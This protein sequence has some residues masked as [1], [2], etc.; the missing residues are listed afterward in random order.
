MEIDLV[1]LS[2]DLSPPRDDVMKGVASQGLAGLRVLRVAGP[3]RPEDPNRWATIARARNEAKHVGSAPFVMFLDDDVVLAPGCVPS[4]LDGLRRR[5]IFA[6]LGADYAEEMAANPFHHWDYPP[7]V[8]MGAVLFRR[9]RLAGINFRWENKR[10]ECACCC[11]DLRSAGLAVGYHPDARATH[12]RHPAAPVAAPAAVPQGRVLAAFNRAHYQKF[13]DRFL[14]SLREAGNTEI[15]TAVAYDLNDDERTAL[16]AMPGVEVAARQSCGVNPAVLRIRDFRE[17]MAEWPDE[18]PVAYWD[19]GDVVFQ[20]RLRPLWQ[21]VRDNPERVLAA[22]EHTTYA[23]NPVARHWLETIH[24]PT[25]RTR[26]LSLLSRRPIL[27]G[28]FL[29][30]TAKTLKNYFREA[31]RLRASVEFRGSVDWSDQTVMNIF[32][33]TNPGAWREAPSGWNY[34]LYRRRVRGGPGGRVESLD[35]TP[36]HVVH[37]NAGSLGQRSLPHRIA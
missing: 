13:I 5:P 36:V 2:R 16:A 27:N 32:C 6:A 15:V 23:E 26:L 4:L 25:S 19:A 33:H 34:C 10:C 3:P 24:D 20:E 31:A 29:A 37:G 28:G 21:L 8:G 12:V 14:R 30:G 18:T 1:L 17:V 7:H 11:D 35:G 22:R 9:E